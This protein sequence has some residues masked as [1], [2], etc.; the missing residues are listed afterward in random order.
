MHEWLKE[1]KAGHKVIVHNRRAEEVRVVDRD[2]PT[3][4]VIGSLKFRRTTGDLV[5]GTMW[6]DCYLICWS[7]DK[8]DKIKETN[9]RDN[10]I[11]FLSQT[12]FSHLPTY[13]LEEISEMVKKEKKT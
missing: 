4:I 13:K 1:L 5:A 2:T 7:Q 9:K 10:L 6:D 11:R 8:E 12:N 3:Q